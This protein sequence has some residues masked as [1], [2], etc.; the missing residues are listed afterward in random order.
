MT[1]HAMEEMA[2]D[3]LDIVDIE[4]AVL[5]GQVVRSEKDDPRGVKYVVEGVAADGE[6]PVGVVGRFRS[7]ERYLLLTVY[8]VG[9]EQ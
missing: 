1:V 2:E 7:S 6:T 9:K 5:T 4:Q 8:E 3:D